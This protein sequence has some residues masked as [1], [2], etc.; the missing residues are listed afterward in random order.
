MKLVSPGWVK[1]SDRSA[2]DCECGEKQSLGIARPTIY[3]PLLAR[4]LRR[5]RVRMS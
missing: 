5:N 1:E 2:Y 3:P 4:S